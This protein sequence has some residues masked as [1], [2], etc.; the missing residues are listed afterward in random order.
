MPKKISS[1]FSEDKY[2]YGFLTAFILLLGQLPIILHIF[3]TP[4]GYYY[5]L[6]DRVSFS[7]YYYIALIRFGMGPE[8]LV[9]VPYIISEHKAS[10]IQVFF[11]WLGKLSLV[12]GIGPAEILAIS[13]I[14]G[15]LVL[16]FA[17]VFVLRIILGKDKARLAFLFFLLSQ[18]LPF[19]AFSKYLF[20]DFDVWMWHFGEAA[21][22][23]SLMP[24]HYN[25]GKGLAILS[26]GALFLFFK[27]KKIKYL[28]AAG[29]LIFAAGII[30]P[31]P[32]FIIVFSLALATAAIVIRKLLS[33]GPVTRVSQSSA[34]RRSPSAHLPNGCALFGSP[35]LASPVW[36]SSFIFPLIFFLLAAIIP[37]M[38]LK[39][40]IAKGYPWD[41]WQKVELGWN[42]PKMHFERDYFS[43]AW[44]LVLLSV[45][46]I[47]K[48]FDRQNLSWTNMFVFF[49]AI[50]AFLLFPFA[51]IFEVG[52]FRLTEGAQIVP[53][54]ILAYFGFEKLCEK[55]KAKAVRKIFISMFI[56]YFLILTI[57]QVMWSTKRLWPHWANVY[58]NPKEVEALTFLEKKV[59]ANSV[60]LSDTFSSNYIAA[61]ARV[62]TVV[63]FP[64][65]FLDIHKYA[66]EESK[67]DAILRGKMPEKDAQNYLSSNKVSNIYSKISTFG[68]HVIYPNLLKIAFQNNLVTVYQNK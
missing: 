52:K 54:S 11:I 66:L 34:S 39:L 42:D 25:F 32:V 9:R 59:K 19:I 33:T 16:I 61:F 20:Q 56:L 5:P 43:I 60:I 46:S 47:K 28:F 12:T 57:C 10:L 51:N 45:F 63:G 24:P 65:F 30:Y 29:F 4:S 48:V 36:I 49:W 18:P 31:P 26:V 41:G 13:R 50:S 2:F 7:D 35:S 37:L 21:R 62:R 22:R 40:E 27:H 17:A 3:H 67:I 14:A 23:I 15:G 38:V 55:I 58:I 64:D 6:L 53:L 1:F 68:D 44:S 8:W